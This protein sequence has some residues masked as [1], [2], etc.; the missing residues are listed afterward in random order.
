M[1]SVSAEDLKDWHMSEIFFSSENQ[2]ACIIGFFGELSVYY[3][4]Y[5]I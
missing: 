2:L 1:F 3:K 4:Y 5:R